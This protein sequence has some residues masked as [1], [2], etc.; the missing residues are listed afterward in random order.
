MC[1][2]ANKILE[3]N[4]MTNSETQQA[5]AFAAMCV[6]ATA[7]AEGCKRQEMYL[8]LKNVGLIHGLTTKL[9]ALHTQ[10]KEYVVADLIQALHRL[11][12]NNNQSKEDDV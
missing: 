6:D 3:S 9:D 2:F 5:L 12:V 10:S 7:K 4:N 1:N 8:R 11:E